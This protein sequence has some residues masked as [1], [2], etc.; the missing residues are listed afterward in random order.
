VQKVIVWDY[1]KWYK[2]CPTLSVC[3]KVPSSKLGSDQQDILRRKKQVFMGPEFGKV[4]NLE[5]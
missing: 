2:L 5:I 1:Q 4:E 3:L